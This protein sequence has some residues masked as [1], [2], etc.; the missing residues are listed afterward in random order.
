[1]Q[2]FGK[3]CTQNPASSRPDLGVGWGEKGHCCHGGR[4]TCCDQASLFLNRVFGVVTLLQDTGPCDAHKRSRVVRRQ[5]A[6][7]FPFVS[8]LPKVRFEMGFFAPQHGRY[9]EGALGAKH[10]SNLEN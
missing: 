6:F 5:I 10:A 3:P 2:T 9:T 1:M 4:L 7:L 8:M